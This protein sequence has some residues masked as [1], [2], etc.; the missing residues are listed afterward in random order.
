MSLYCILRFFC[1]R[2]VKARIIDSYLS[3]HSG[4]AIEKIHLRMITIQISSRFLKNFIPSVHALRVPRIAVSVDE[5][6]GSC[7]SIHSLLNSRCSKPRITVQKRTA[8]FGPTKNIC[9]ND[10]V[11]RRMVFAVEKFT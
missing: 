6:E 3:L 11:A 10:S 5:S 7:V 4:P 8:I 9:Q 1:E 2:A